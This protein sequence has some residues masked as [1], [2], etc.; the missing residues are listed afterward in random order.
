MAAEI[1]ISLVR[2]KLE[3]LR[4]KIGDPSLL[5]QVNESIAKLEES[6]ETWINLEDDQGSHLTID[7][8][9]SDLLEAVYDAEDTIDAF[10]AC[11][12]LQKQKSF[13]LFPL[14][15][16][17]SQ[18]RV[19]RKMRD[20]VVRLTSFI[21]NK[22]VHVEPTAPSSNLSLE[23]M[24]VDDDVEVHP[25]KSLTNEEDMPVLQLENKKF[26]EGTSKSN[27]GEGTSGSK[28][29]YE[30]GT[31]GLV[32][33]AQT[34]HDHV[35]LRLLSTNSVEDIQVQPSEEKHCVDGNVGP[36]VGADA[37]ESSSSDE[38]DSS[39]LEDT[40]KKL[41][42][43]IFRDDLPF[44]LL[45]V[46][47]RPGGSHNTTLLWRTYCNIKEHFECC[48][49]T[50]VSD[51]YEAIKCVMEQLTGMKQENDLPPRVL[52]R[53]LCRF[54]SN[55]KY[56]LVFYDLRTPEVWESLSS[57]LPNSGGGRTIVSFHAA[58]AAPSIPNARFLGTIFGTELVSPS[59]LSKDV[60]ASLDEETDIV[61]LKDEIQKLH[62]LICRR[63]QLHFMILVVG[64]AGSGKTTLVN[65]VYN[66]LH[67]KQKFENRVWIS[68]SKVFEERNLLLQILKQV[69]EV[70]DEEKLSLEELRKKLRYFF[71]G[72]RY[73]VVLDD[74][75]TPDTWD[76]L[77]RV[78]PISYVSGSRVV[79][80]IRDAKIAQ[81]ID[82][83]IYYRHNLRPLNNEESWELFSEKLKPK[84]SDNSDLVELKEKILQKCK[85]LPLAICMLAGLLS[86][87]E[88]SKDAWL[89]VIESTQQ[90]R[91]GGG[92]GENAM[93]GKKEERVTEYTKL[94]KKEQSASEHSQPDEI[95]EA[96]VVEEGKRVSEHSQRVEIKEKVVEDET[97][98]D[99]HTHLEKI[100]EAEEMDEER[101]RAG[102]HI[103]QGEIEEEGVGKEEKRGNVNGASYSKQGEDQSIS[104]NESVSSDNLSASDIFSLGYRDLDFPLRACL[105]YLCLFP[106]SDSIRIRRLARL[107]IAEGLVEVSENDKKEPEDLVEEYLQQLEQRNMIKIE[108]SDGRPKECR[109]EGLPY[110][111]LCPNA[112]R[113]G[114][115]HVHRNS[116]PESETSAKLR[117]R[118]LAEQVDMIKIE[119]SDGRPKEC[120]VEGLPY[121]LL[122]PNAKCMGFFH[123]HPN[124]GPESKTAAK[125]SIRRLAEQVDIQNNPPSDE[126]I[127]QL[128]SYISF[129]KGKGDKAAEG[130]GNFL[131]RTITKRSFGL[132]TLLDLERVYKPVL[133]PETLRRL[134]L[135]K[136]VGLRW[137][138]LDE[139]P[140]SLGDIPCLETLDVKHTN[141]SELPNSIRNA[142][143]LLHL[144]MN[145]VDFE[146]S[147]Q[148][149]SSSFSDLQTL[150][151]LLIGNNSPTITWLTKLNS[152]RKL[153]LTCHEESIGKITNW[154][155]QLNSLRSL[156]LRSVDDN[157]KPSELKLKRIS[158]EMLTDLY[159]VGELPKEFKISE[160]EHLS[161]LRVLTL[162]VSKLLEDPMQALGQLENLRILRLYAES[163]LG[164]KMNLSGSAGRF[165][166]LEVLKLWMLLNLTEL[167]IEE[168]AMPVLREL[169]IR[170][171]R[172]LRKPTGLEGL[173]TLKKLTLTNMNKHFVTEVER[174]I[175]K[176][177]EVIVNN[178][179]FTPSWESSEEQEQR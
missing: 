165:S 30:D 80:T 41:A 159:L 55:K 163:Y 83:S 166:K 95:V 66:Q 131:K 60:C 31:Y 177:T 50:Y 90:K 11:T 26:G 140:E 82:S 63:Y 96:K 36:D 161:K 115:F 70:K 57:V 35:K 77:K 13:P 27:F 65:T 89:K 145:G 76:K 120:S 20:I 93:Q 174:S 3:N 88:R 43:L 42:E 10:L 40:A 56:L 176:R 79:L 46:A 150:S 173:T 5:S 28:F 102:E 94:E 116:G 29:S 178:W 4:T 124:S 100:E 128:R 179:H 122:C 21:E 85:G 167:K 1:T 74:V 68:V 59:A 34:E 53:K 121:D 25:Q 113:M 44:L 169:E 147:K 48:A 109:V 64:V 86:T 134:P 38:D 54:L 81:N 110:D 157:G 138:F 98:L 23:D 52:Q 12:T 6:L 156:R 15:S 155:S 61:G 106:R 170:H 137:T 62:K 8:R 22:S 126:D 51:V 14:R 114:F 108:K 9:K 146:R 105:Q 107:W 162:S 153:G 143:K 141:I 168:R 160:V 117:I 67:I 2:E 37:S 72:K 154:L 152:L 69:T 130:V 149:S 47:G 17:H 111:L 164:D 7:D 172:E 104:S 33:T 58:A 19:S 49:W 97:G 101:K 71:V 73:L 118:R 151:G 24:K 103:Q 45:S 158:N 78:F 125:L 39:D 136:Y 16:E 92:T 148:I 144:Y 84:I 112:T 87:K 133:I 129:N 135:L 142:E 139:I 18:S 132:L 175:G 119:K 171:C 127:R 91:K 123:V 99:K 32:D 75:Q